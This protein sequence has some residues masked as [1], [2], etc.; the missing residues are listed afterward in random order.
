MAKAEFYNSQ[1]EMERLSTILVNLPNIT[2]LLGI[3]LDHVTGSR[4][5]KIHF[6]CLAVEAS[7][8]SDM[9]ECLSVDSANWIRFP[10]GAGKIFSLEDNHMIATSHMIFL[11]DGFNLSLDSL[12]HMGVDSIQKCLK[13]WYR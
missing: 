10:A 1:V 9:V 6:Y 13:H 4:Y 7:F 12:H 5:M 3:S 11:N 2:V 8:Y